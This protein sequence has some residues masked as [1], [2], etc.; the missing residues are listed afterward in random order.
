MEKMVLLFWAMCV[1]GSIAMHLRLSDP[2]PDQVRLYPD[3]YF[4]T[5]ILPAVGVKFLRQVSSGPIHLN[6]R[7]FIFKVKN[8]SK[9]FFSPILQPTASGG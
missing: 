2:S 9:I 4:L 8:T 1:L 3:M 5:A 7:V 6:F